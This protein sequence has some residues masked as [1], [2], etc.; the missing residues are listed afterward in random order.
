MRAFRNSSDNEIRLFIK[1]NTS[2][3]ASSYIGFDELT[4]RKLGLL[5]LE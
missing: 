3:S 4:L 5:L 1:A 2:I